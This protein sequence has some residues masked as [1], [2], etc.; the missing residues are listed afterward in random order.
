MLISRKYKAKH[1]EAL[2]FK[3]EADWEK[4]VLQPSMSSIAESSHTANSC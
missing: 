1:W 2:T 4:A 3:S